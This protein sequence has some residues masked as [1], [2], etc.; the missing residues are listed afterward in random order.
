MAQSIKYIPIGDKIELNL[1]PDPQRD[2]RVGQAQDVSR[3]I[4]M[5]VNG[6]EVFRKVGQS[7]VQVEENSTV[8]GWNEH[9]EDAQRIRNFTAAAIEV[10][11]RRT[12]SGDVT[13]RSQLK[14]ILH[15]YQ[16]VQFTATIEAGKKSDLLFEVVLRQGHNA[17]QNNVTLE[18][19][20][21]R[22]LTRCLA[23]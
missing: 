13:F 6:A 16:T 12:F 17:K 15:N 8:A 2:F 19:G 3:E 20:P 4:W 10:E 7:G 1:G 18:V 22:T 5:A 14:P 9:E 23:L 21:C 11:V